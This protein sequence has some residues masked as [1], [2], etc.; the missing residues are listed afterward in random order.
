MRSK[1]EI[2]TDLAMEV[3]ESFP[4]DG[5]EI[6]GVSL[7]KEYLKD[8][9]IKVTKVEILN[10]EGSKL[11]GKAEGSYITLEAKNMD[12]EDEGYH[13]E[14]SE[15]MASY[16]KELLPG[17]E[18]SK[19]LIV[20][21]G[22]G[23]ATPDALGPK[24]VGNM[25]MTRHL[26]VEYG[27]KA[28]TEW[29]LMNISGIVPGVM[30]QTGMETAEIIRGVVEKTGPDVVIVIDALAARSIHR[31]GTTIQLSDTGIQPGSG[32]G[33]HR[34]SLTEESLGVPVIAVGVPTV[35]GAAAIVQDTMDTMI[36][37]LSK[38]SATGSIADFV[39]ESEPEDQYTLIQ[40]L[41]MPEFGAMYVTPKDIDETVK[42]LSFTISEGLHIALQKS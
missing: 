1:F 36:E 19:I 37:V 20:G 14:I 34:N 41:L 12:K 22:N 8:L 32:V 7:E 15:T 28:G 5:G 4:G 42:R 23:E 31:L 17:G 2:R 11:M 24:V 29:G 25:Q 6:P 13:R 18:D 40:E 39:K 30:A 16:L 35:V 26:F 9:D 10:Q 3:R 33:N 21:L 27:D 38:N